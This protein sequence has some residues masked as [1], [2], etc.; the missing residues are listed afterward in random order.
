M[1]YLFTLTALGLWCC[2][3]ALSSC[4][5]WELLSRTVHAW[6]SQGSGFSCCRTQALECTGFSSC[7]AWPQRMQLAGSRAW[8][9]YLWHT[10]FVVPWNVASSQPRDWTGGLCIAKQILNHWTNREVPCCSFDLNIYLITSHA[11]HLFMC[12][13]ATCI[14]VGKCLF[15]SSAHFL[16]RL[17][18]FFSFWTFSGMSF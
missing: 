12:Q 11:E 1:D 2:V 16:I 5:E 10:D 13:V 7:G 6:T 3:W 15:R 8:T 17:L 14:S 4:G 9:Q 18:F